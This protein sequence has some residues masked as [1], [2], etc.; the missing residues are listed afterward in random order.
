VAAGYDR[1][2][3]AEPQRFARI[4]A[5]RPREAVWTSVLDAVKGRG[6]LR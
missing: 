2:A 3:R 1:R 4:F 5:D 6:W